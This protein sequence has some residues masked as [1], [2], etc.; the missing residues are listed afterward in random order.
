MNISP[1]TLNTMTN[2]KISALFTNA[3]LS[4]YENKKSIAKP[5]F[6]LLSV[7]QNQENVPLDIYNEACDWIEDKLGTASLKLIGLEIGYMLF[8]TLLQ[9]AKVAKDSHPEDVIEAFEVLTD[10]LV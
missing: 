3:I 1:T 8:D 10:K 2:I 5:L 7:Y 6:E 9:N 4:Y